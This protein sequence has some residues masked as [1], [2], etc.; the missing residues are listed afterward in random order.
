MQ[1][2]FSIFFLLQYHIYDRMINDENIEFITFNNVHFQKSIY[3]RAPVR[4][5]CSDCEIEK[6]NAERGQLRQKKER[7][8]ER[9]VS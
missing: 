4:S 7:E 1:Q 8:K 6:L 3:K 5:L 9:R 2:I